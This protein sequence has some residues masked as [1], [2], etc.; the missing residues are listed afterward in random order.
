MNLSTRSPLALALLL[1]ALGLLTPPPAQENAPA[2]AGLTWIPIHWESA[3]IGERL[4]EK[5]A[6]LVPVQ[7]EGKS[8]KILVQLDLGADLT[9]FDAA[10]YEQ[11][12]GKGTAPRDKPKKMPFTGTFGGARVQNYLFDV[13]PGGGEKSSGDEP[14]LL[15]TLGADFFQK[16]ILLLDFIGQ[17]IRILDEDG[18]LPETLENR[19]T[20]VPLTVR[21][22][23]LFVPLSINGKEE[24]GFFYDTG[25]SLFTIT[26]TRAKWQE[27]TGRTGN[28]PDNEVWR[29]P[30]WG[31]EAVMVGARTKGEV[32]VGNA[33]LEHPLAFFESSGLENLNAVSLF[34]NALFFGRFSVIV[35]IPGKR[36]GLIEKSENQ[37]MQ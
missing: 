7:L 21:D 35:D 14:V 13:L 24:G 30:S 6:L 18:R 37:G 22:G 32:R 10:P 11:L 19:A 28:E 26:T 17:R 16:R 5:A 9:Q 23:R 20:F 31:R 34:G 8:A 3:K 25:S 27:I 4:V 12:F 2:A 1:A 29:V 36:F 33:R 15:G